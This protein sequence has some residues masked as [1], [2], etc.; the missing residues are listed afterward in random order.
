MKGKRLGLAEPRSSEGPLGLEHGLRGGAPPALQGLL[1]RHA[2]AGPGALKEAGDWDQLPLLGLHR[3]EQKTNRKK[4][5]PGVLQGLPWTAPNR[6]PVGKGVWE[7]WLQ[8]SS[9]ASQSQGRR[10]DVE[11]RGNR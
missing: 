8:R 9:A 2:R 3:Q 4:E 11:L 10:V 6:K 5:V 7:T 1:H